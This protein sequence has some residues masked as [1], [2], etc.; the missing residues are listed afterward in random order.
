MVD[1]DPKTRLG[2]ELLA[3]AARDHQRGAEE[4]KVYQLDPGKTF[5]PKGDES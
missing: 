1:D 5:K 4:P 2:I 3:E